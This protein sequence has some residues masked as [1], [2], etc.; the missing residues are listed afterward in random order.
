MWFLLSLLFRL[1][2]AR[3]RACFNQFEV[4]VYI[5]KILRDLTKV[6][7]IWWLRVSGNQHHQVIT[8]RSWSSW[9]K[10]KIFSDQVVPLSGT[11]I[12]CCAIV[13]IRSGSRRYCGTISARRLK[14]RLFGWPR[15]SVSTDPLS[16]EQ[17]RCTLCRGPLGVSISRICHTGCYNIFSRT[18][19]SKNANISIY[20]SSEICDSILRFSSLQLVILTI[21]LKFFAWTKKI[22]NV[23]SLKCFTAVYVNE[24]NR[25]YLVQ[26]L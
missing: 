16:Q 1:K 17:T 6:F 19:L 10:Q 12:G 24:M 26:L 25:E 14:S 7:T 18:C 11:G 15:P 13:A 3:T 9:A 22:C 5:A 20:V 4:S 23:L 2:H 21:D 8:V